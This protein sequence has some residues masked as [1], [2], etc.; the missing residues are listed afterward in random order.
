MGDDPVSVARVGPCCGVSRRG[1]PVVF[2]L[3][4]HLESAEEQETITGLSQFGIAHG[5]ITVTPQVTEAV[6]HWDFAR[7]SS[8]LA[9]LGALIRHIE[10]TQCVDQR[11]VFFAGYS[12]GAFMASYLA[13]QDASRIAAVAT[14]AG[15]QA[16]PSCHPSRP[17]P[18]IAFHGTADPF[19]PY[20]GGVGPAAASLPGPNGTG[21]LGSLIGTPAVA[22]VSPSTAPIPKEEARWAA[23]N[24]CAASPKRST[25]AK[26]VTLIAY[27]CPKNA[28]VEL[29]R[30]NGD[31]HIWAGSQGM[32]A[33]RKLVGP[34][35][36][37]ISADKLL[38]ASFR[39]HPL[40]GS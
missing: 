12:N 2:D 28:T 26:G 38:W 20:D 4:G 16:P 8:D 15:I 13:C 30:E 24:G 32:I 6:P 39:S 10:A 11:R 25:V 23:R 37:S 3:H 5:F 33:L 21:T 29:Y 14:I 31:G 27:R 34:T 9:F 1:L 35:T 36:F 18:V 40:S 22:G 19:V 7:G 17:V